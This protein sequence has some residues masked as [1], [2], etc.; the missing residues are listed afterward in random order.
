MRKH[1]ALLIAA[2]GLLLCSSCRK[3]PIGNTAQEQVPDKITPK[4]TNVV[5]NS[6]G[7]YQITN[8]SSG[9]C[10]E[11]SGGSLNNGGGVGQWDYLAGGTTGDVNPNF[12]N[13]VWQLID[14]GNGYYKIM[15]L[16]SGKLLGSSF[17][18]P[19]LWQNVDDGSDFELWQL[20]QVG[21]GAYKIINKA[22]NLAATNS[23]GATNNGAP[24]TQETF[25]SNTTQYWVITLVS[26]G[27]YRDDAVVNFFHRGKVANTTV[28]FDEGTSIPLTD[29]RVLWFT[30]DAFKSDQLNSSNMF[31]CG[32][33]FSVSNSALIQPSKSNFNSAATPNMITNNSTKALEVFAPPASNA[34]SW[35]SAGIEI[36]SHVYVQ[37][38][39]GVYGGN[40]LNQYLYDLTENSG[41]NW[42]TAQKLSVP[43]MTNQNLATGNPWI[44]WVLGMVKPGD[45]YVYVFGGYNANCGSF[46]FSTDVYA[47]RFPANNSSVTNWTYW[48][49]TSFV[50]N[51]PVSSMQKIGSGYANNGSVYV[52]YVNGKYVL[53][54]LDNGFIS[55]DGSHNIYM[56]VSANPFI[57]GSQNTFSSAKAVFSIPDMFAGHIAKFYTPA[58]HP[59]FNNGRN[60]LL[61]TYCLNYSQ[62][63]QDACQN[64]N[65]DPNYYQVK[66]VRVPYSLIGL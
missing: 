27:A 9:K 4:A 34:W 57:A 8:V 10:M 47:A 40:I 56:A 17:P 64:N 46:C 19:Q 11:V 13:Q 31:N 26:A 59:E 7:A 35:P 36:G 21:F 49:G 3:N 39:E 37:S 52:S 60:E 58:I 5:V 15:N 51:I 16:R 43:G 30:Q 29:G 53:M 24:I 18:G 61:V 14:Q 33:I 38:T 6:Y 32:S 20:T 50:A 42:G 62:C 45:G 28:A 63:G 1:S 66:G 12:N 25:A 2:A 55:C 41:T 22:N 23:G 65:V 48:N 44:S 54:S